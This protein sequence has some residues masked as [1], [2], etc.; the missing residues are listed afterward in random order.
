GP[1]AWAVPSARAILSLLGGWGADQK[2]STPI[3]ASTLGLPTTPSR[4]PP[5]GDSPI[6]RHRRSS[7]T[8]TPPPVRTPAASSL[9]R[10]RRPSPPRRRSPVPLPPPLT[11]AAPSPPSTSS[12]AA[13]SDMSGKSKGGGERPDL[14][15]QARESRSLI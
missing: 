12:P 3:P 15:I 7:P 8:S 6:R 11:N 4:P 10:P 14:D 2:G 5:V 9:P 13:R 1:W